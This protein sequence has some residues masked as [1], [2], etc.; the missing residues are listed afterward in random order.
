M[1]RTK[2]RIAEGRPF[3]AHEDIYHFALDAMSG[4]TFGHGFDHSSI[5]PTSEAIRSLDLAAKEKLRG[6]GTSQDPVS[7]PHGKMPGVLWAFMEL[8]ELVAY[9][10]GNPFPRLTW[11]FV[12]RKPASRKAY[13]IKED[14]IRA[15]VKRAVQRLGEGGT[16]KPTSAVDYIVAREKALA[17]KAGKKPDYFSRVIV[18]EVCFHPS[19]CVCGSGCLWW[20]DGHATNPASIHRSSESS[21]PATRQQAPC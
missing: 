14:F 15:E 12:L 10:L 5:Q 18:D 20:R 21:T 2:A 17:E 4:F 7:F 3:D 1:W 16:E 6:T 19:S 13:R 8:T 11:S 9:M